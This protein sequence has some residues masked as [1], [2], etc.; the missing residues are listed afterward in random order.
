MAAGVFMSACSE[1]K[2][3]N[4]LLTE[5]NT[6]FGI[7]PF[8]LVK[9][10][11][12]MPAFKTAMAAE[13]AEIDAITGNKEEP[14]F[15]NTILAFDKTGELY[16]KV[17]AVFGS[18]DGV[19][20]NDQIRAIAKE[21]SPLESA[22]SSAISLNDKLFQRI[23]SVYDKRTELNLDAD[24]VRLVEETYKDFER[25][26]ANLPADKKE[27]LKKLNAEINALELDFGQNLLKETAAYSLVIDKAEDL[28]G[29]T[30]N[31]IAEAA[32][33]AEKAGNAGK[34]MFGLDNP[35]IMPFLANA[36][37][38]ELRKQ[39]FTAYTNRCNNNNENDNKNI[40][41]KLVDLRLKKAQIMGAETSAGF[42]LEDRMA[43]TPQ[44]V[45]ELLDQIWTPAIK[46]ANSEA[47]DMRNIIAKEKANIELEG[48]DWRFY[49]QKAMNSKF[50]LS[51]SETAP[52]FKLENVR[53]GIFYVANKLYGLTFKQLS[54]VPLPNPEAV[55]F[56]VKD[57]DSS[58]L[59]VVFFDMFARPGA[60]SGGAWCGGYRS[61]SYKDGKRV[62]PL[63]TI[64]G[65]FTRPIGDQPALLTMDEV[66]TYFHEFGHGL[67][68][69]LRNVKYKGL[70]GYPRD[71]VELPSQINE[72]WAFAPEVLKVYAKHY[73]TGEII[74]QELVD[75]MVKAG[76]YGQGFATTEYLAA[77][78]LDMDYH[79]FKLIPADLD[80]EKFEA[81]VLGDRG[82]LSQIPPRYRSTYFSHTF[83]GG[84]TAGYYSYIWAEVLD[85][86][87]FQAFVETGDIFNREVATKFRK[88]VLERADEAD[89]MDLYVNFRGKKPGIEPLL[90]NRG[91]L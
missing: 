83:T 90:K 52:Y 89:A 13:L 24:Q 54:N 14:T 53:E 29:L 18:N 70:G 30:D 58:H 85:A 50:N 72:H 25:G 10:E 73:K 27:E 63:V 56:E 59:G 2:E 36:E 46:V 22:H 31:Q 67:A 6:P 51:E 26:G 37:N 17:S 80:V 79:V 78:Y 44:A 87:A 4:P 3:E 35:S 76:K 5:W 8:E 66:E 49:A 61:Q 60:K 28:K 68:S 82:I 19:N 47:N 16:S 21:L 34:W 1:V 20:S 77:S 81:K 57:S 11:H 55:A 7:P 75:K 84:Y 48:W 12:Y 74:P 9:P 43:K 88:E 45:Y 65:N 32:S 42:I 64:V 38:R 33:R 71:F 69:L 86:D 62:A 91:L 23:K 41:K 40:I 39:I 15:D